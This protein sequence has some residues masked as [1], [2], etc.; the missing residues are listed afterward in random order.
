M[1]L[2]L[3]ISTKAIEFYNYQKNTESQYHEQENKTLKEECERIESSAK[4]HLQDANKKI[5]IL[6]KQLEREKNE[7]EQLQKKKFSTR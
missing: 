6:T 1:V 7:R 4:A 2:V 5:K 3:E